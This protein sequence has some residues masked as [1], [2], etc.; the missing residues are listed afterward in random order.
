MKN[1]SY[2]ILA[3]KAVL[4]ALFLTLLCIYKCLMDL[5][6]IFEIYD[7]CTECINWRMSNDSM[8]SNYTFFV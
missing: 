4:M 1:D 6:N 2:I 3:A 7:L 8:N 5:Q